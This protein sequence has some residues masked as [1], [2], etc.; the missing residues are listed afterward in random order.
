MAWVIRLAVGSYE[1]R[2]ADLLFCRYS[3]EGA[4]L[5]GKRLSRT[6]WDMASEGLARGGHELTQESRPRQALS[7]QLT[8]RS[9]FL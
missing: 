6:T 2:C 5:T 7:M 9:S 4:N 8:C 3:Q 1:R